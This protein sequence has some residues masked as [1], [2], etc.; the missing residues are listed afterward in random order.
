MNITP[1]EIDS[2]SKFKIAD[3]KTDDT[4][5]FEGK[6]EVEN[7][8]AENILKIDKLQ[9]KLHAQDKYSLLIIFQAMDTAGKD[10]AIKHVMAGLN[11]QAT[12]VHS[13]KQPSLEELDH[14]YL[15]RASKN[16]PERGQIGIFN[17]SYYE[18]VLVV[19]VHDLVKKQHLPQE[20]IT[21]NI[22]RD[23]FRQIRDYEKYLHENGIVI[24]KF[25]LHISKEEQKK[26]LLARI[27]DKSKNWK[28]EESDIKERQ[29]WDDYQMCYQDAIRET[30]AKH[31]PWFVVPSDKKWFSRLVISE[32]IVQAMQKLNL[33]YPTISQEQNDV[34]K[35]CRYRLM[36]E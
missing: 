15:W 5:K 9:D 6:N 23:R 14:D 20:F 21:D 24:L 16:L 11:P 1:Y 10:G 30:S 31:A 13:F 22:W 34:L 8:L 25:F 32:V 33:E 3:I 19:R 29:F 27:D 35:E 28:F 18:D 26:R 2:D 7:I 12:H 17:R 36:N 4:S